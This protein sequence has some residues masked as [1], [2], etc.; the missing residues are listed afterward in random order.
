MPHSPEDSCWEQHC[1]SHGEDEPQEPCYR[2]CGEC[3]HVFPTAA[4]LV[5]DHNAEVQAMMARW[6]GELLTAQHVDE[7][8]SCPWCSH[9]W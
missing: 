8:L 5:R 1:C 9:N 6:G 3:Y 7:I 4:D 2:A